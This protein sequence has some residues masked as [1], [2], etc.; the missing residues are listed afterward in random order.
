MTHNPSKQPLFKPN[1]LHVFLYMY[2]FFAKN[3][4]LYKRTT[5][6]QNLYKFVHQK[7]EVKRVHVHLYKQKNAKNRDLYMK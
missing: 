4:D 6:S 1:T 7:H 3:T 2:K 5:P